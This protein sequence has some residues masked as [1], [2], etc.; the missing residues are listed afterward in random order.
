[1]YMYLGSRLEGINK[2]VKVSQSQEDDENDKMV[3]KIMSKVKVMPRPGD[4]NLETM[5]ISKLVPSTRETLLQPVSSIE[6]DSFNMK[7]LLLW[8]CSASTTSEVKKI[9]PL[10]GWLCH[11]KMDKEVLSSSGLLLS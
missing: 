2:I 8:P 7:N 5:C 9:R 6:S 3:R 11:Y 10:F 4:K 1:M